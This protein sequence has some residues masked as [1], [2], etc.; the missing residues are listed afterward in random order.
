MR[1]FNSEFWNDMTLEQCLMLYGLIGSLPG[2]ALLG[3][4]GLML[5]L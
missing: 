4:S 3:Y 2:F 5:C 1:L